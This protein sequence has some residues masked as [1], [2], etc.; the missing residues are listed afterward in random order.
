[1]TILIPNFHFWHSN[2]GSGTHCSYRIFIKFRKL[3]EIS[4][5]VN[6]F[7]FKPRRRID[8]VAEL[9]VLILC[10]VHKHDEPTAM[11]SVR[12]GGW[13]ASFLVYDRCCKFGNCEIINILYREIY[14]SVSLLRVPFK[15]KFI[16]NKKNL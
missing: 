9:W 12:L 2:I 10:C 16:Y 3:S 6:S 15:Y 8:K 4:V 5:N 13:D 11:S 14:D 1:M 7:S